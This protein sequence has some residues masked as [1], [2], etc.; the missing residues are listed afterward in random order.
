MC[1][2]F[3]V[4]FSVVGATNVVDINTCAYNFT[5]D[6]KISFFCSQQHFER[7]KKTLLFNKCNDEIGIYIELVEGK[8][9]KYMH[10]Q[11]IQYPTK[12]RNGKYLDYLRIIFNEI[13]VAVQALI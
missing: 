2:L 4:C 6:E 12:N 5:V 1:V 8:K 11:S 9:L 13:V 3:C 10:K 7:W